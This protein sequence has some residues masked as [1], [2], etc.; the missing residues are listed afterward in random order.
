[1]LKIRKEGLGSLSLYRDGDELPFYVG[2]SADGFVVFLKV[3]VPPE[4]SVER[5]AD[6]DGSI[7]RFVLNRQYSNIRTTISVRRNPQMTWEFEV[8]AELNLKKW[9]RASSI[10][11]LLR[12]APEICRQM[13]NTTAFNVL[14]T[15]FGLIG[16][17]DSQTYIVDAMADAFATFQRLLDGV[18]KRV[19]A[20]ASINSGR[21]RTITTEFSFPPDVRI[22]CEQ[23]LLH[24]VDFLLDLGVD[25]RAELQ[26]TAS[27]V[28]FSVT[29]NDHHQALDR[30]RTALEVYLALPRSE[31]VIESVSELDNISFQKLQMNIHHLQSQLAA[32]NVQR[33]ALATTVQAQQITIDVLNKGRTSAAALPSLAASQEPLGSESLFGGL[34]SVGKIE[35]G[36]V[37]VNL[38]ELYR[39]MRKLLK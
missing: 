37:S 4:L 31:L 5:L 18:D 23:Y 3:N 35:R 7:A 34:V 14:A 19:H 12:E 10:D 2:S 36:G 11:R 15:G 13:G 16:P 32:A 22:A 20:D 9:R 26:E 24:F 17:V 28:L 1:M 38:A 21:D 30:I 25:A 29:P 39:R 27:H 33:L 6:V 8:A